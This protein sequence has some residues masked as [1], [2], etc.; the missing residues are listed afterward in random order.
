LLH[1][2][3]VMTKRL[4]P[5]RQPTPAPFAM[6]SATPNMAPVKGWAAQTAIP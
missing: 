5:G 4:I 2:A 1:A 3:C 6:L